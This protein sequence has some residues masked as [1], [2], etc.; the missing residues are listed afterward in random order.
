MWEYVSPWMLPSRFGP[1]TAVFRAY[2]IADGDPRLEGLPLDPL[3]T[4][5]LN[6]TYRVEQGSP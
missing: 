1:T 2:R 6:A 3:D 4:N 5:V